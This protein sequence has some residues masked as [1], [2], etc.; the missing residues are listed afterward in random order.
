ML[1]DGYYGT[2]GR[3]LRVHLAPHRLPQGHRPAGHGLGQRP[4]GVHATTWARASASCAATARSKVGINRGFALACAARDGRHYVMALPVGADHAD[5][6]P[7]RGLAARRRRAPGAHVA[8]SA[9]SRACSSARAADCIERGQGTLGRALL[10]RRAGGRR[11]RGQ[12]AR[13]D[14]ARRAAARSAGRGGGAARC[15]A[16][17]A[18]S[19]WWP[20][21]SE[22][23]ERERTSRVK[24]MKLVMVGNGMAGVRTL[25]ELLKIAPDLY[26]ITVFGAEPHP[27]YNRILLSRRCWPASRRSTRS[28][29]TRWPGTPT[30]ASRCTWARRWSTSTARERMRDRRR[31]HRGRR[32]TA[33]CWPPAP[34]PS[35]CRCRARTCTA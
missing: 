30:T 35:S 32:T 27:N 23:R 31:R 14:W 5:R 3:R 34:T 24:K 22:A 13:R 15:C 8:A 18:A 10:D 26:D 16:T 7:L 11:R 29:S 33:C 6:A 21:T 28:C 25:E 9:K 1:A 19:P 12:R 2:T 17:A 4:A 20:G